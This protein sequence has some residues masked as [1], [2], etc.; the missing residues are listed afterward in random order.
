MSVL[1][2]LLAGAVAGL[3]F[4]YS[5]AMFIP[6]MALPTS[7]WFKDGSA[8]V[9][10]EEVVGLAASAEFTVEFRPGSVACYV[11]EEMGGRFPEAIYRVFCRVVP[12]REEAFPFVNRVPG[13]L[14]P[15]GSQW[16]ARIYG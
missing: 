12:G 5:I 14:S 2:C 16:I 9:S 7:A 6:A 15:D 13:E 3:L 11:S 1:C 10:F 4:S 8:F